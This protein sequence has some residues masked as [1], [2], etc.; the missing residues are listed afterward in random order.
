MKSTARIFALRAATA[1]TLLIGLSSGG[2]APVTGIAAAQTQL[3]PDNH[4][5]AYRLL[6]TWQSDRYDFVFQPKV[7][8]IGGKPTQGLTYRKLERASQREL[9]RGALS[10]DFAGGLLRGSV[11]SG[12]ASPVG[13]DDQPPLKAWVDD[14]GR[15]WMQRFG[16]PFNVL[17]EGKFFARVPVIVD[18]AKT[19]RWT[20]RWNTN[21]GVLEVIAE[22]TNFAA[23]IIRDGGRKERVAFSADTGQAAGAWDSEYTEAGVWMHKP[24]NWGDLSLSLSPDGQSFTGWYTTKKPGAIMGLERREWTGQRQAASAPGQPPSAPQTPSP[25]SASQPAPV[26][27]V[28]AA[29]FSRFADDWK[30]QSGTM[31]IVRDGATGVAMQMLDHYGSVSRQIKVGSGDDGNSLE[32]EW[33]GLLGATP[34]RFRLILTNNGTDFESRLVEPSGQLGRLLW[35]GYS[36]ARRVAVQPRPVEPAPQQPAPQQPAPQQPQVPAQN[37][38]P[39]VAAFKSL[40]RVDVRLDRVVVA[41]GYPTHQVH[42]FVTV[43]NASPGPQYFTSGFMKVLLTDADGVALERSQP[44]RASG[45]PAELFAATPVIQPGAELKARYIFV[46][47]VDAQL[48]TVTLSEGGKSASFPVSGL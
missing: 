22:G 40:N 6:G 29:L 35:S 34:T 47:P 15:L 28:S 4:V 41:R 36:E 48:T 16:A 20:G 5:M 42:A 18:E 33:S 1:I 30:T 21:R 38:P 26:Q 27:P 19:R 2:I 9:E 39:A 45:E 44:Y 37:P 31:R 12:Q 3:A 23:Y 43:K 14:L 13:F 24:V 25:P 10:P 17:E 46:P 7:T 11:V 32:G 8:G